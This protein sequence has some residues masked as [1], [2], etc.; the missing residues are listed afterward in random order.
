M[1]LVLMMSYE[2]KYRTEGENTSNNQRRGI[3]TRKEIR[4]EKEQS[5]INVMKTRQNKN[6][7]NDNSYLSNIT[8]KD[9]GE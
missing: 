7:N 2:T 4:E 6:K 8:K 9:I 3:Q 1:I 5:R